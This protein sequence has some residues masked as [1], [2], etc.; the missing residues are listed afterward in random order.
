[1]QKHV[2]KQKKTK[3]QTLHFIYNKL[4]YFL[5]IKKKNRGG[6]DKV[7]CPC[8]QMNKKIFFTCKLKF[9]VRTDEVNFFFSLSLF[10]F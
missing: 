10:L 4:Q 3:E 6:K 9:F 1:M 8:P 2:H 5:A 7:C